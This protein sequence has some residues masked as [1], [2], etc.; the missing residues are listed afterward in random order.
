MVTQK[1]HKSMNID[2]IVMIFAVYGHIMPINLHAKNEG[3]LPRGFHDRPI[4]TVRQPVR[5]RL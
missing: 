3:N 5:V 4:A 1:P 2:Q